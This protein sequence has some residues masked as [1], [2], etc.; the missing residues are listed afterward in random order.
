MN[1][2]PQKRLAAEILK[3]GVNRLYI[4]PEG[5]EDVQ[6]AITRD[7]V[8]NL[9][10]NKVI[11][12]KYKRGNSRARIRKKIKQKKKGR[13]RGLGSRKGKKSARSNPKRNWINNI[14]PLR[15]E[16]KKLRDT[17]QIDRKIYRELYMKAKGG[18]FDSVS[19]LHRYISENKM[20]NN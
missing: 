18:V 19:T 12:K 14:R 4:H 3:C 9:I 2:E 20:L 11:V 17:K 8:R 13:S 15:K 16:L 5:I 10:K 6:M 7:D 1:I